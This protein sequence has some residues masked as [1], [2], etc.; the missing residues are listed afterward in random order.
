MQ[1]LSNSGVT[2]FDKAQYVAHKSDSAMASP[3]QTARLAGSQA[4]AAVGGNPIAATMG[5][6][7]TPSSASAETMDDGLASIGGLTADSRRTA[8]LVPGQIATAGDL[9]GNQS[10]SAMSSGASQNLEGHD[11]LDGT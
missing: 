11:S 10:A 8:A 7:N 1:S 5:Q 2:E 9:Y 4:S 6:Q 3:V